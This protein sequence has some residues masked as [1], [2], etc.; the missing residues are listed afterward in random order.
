VHLCERSDLPNQVNISGLAEINGKNEASAFNSLQSFGTMHIQQ[1]LM[2]IQLLTVI[3]HV[4]IRTLSRS[5]LRISQSIPS[6]IL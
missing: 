1:W 4:M 3:F 6:F 2:D 5:V